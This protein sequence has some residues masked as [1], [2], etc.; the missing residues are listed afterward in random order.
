MPS[1]KAYAAT[2]LWAR[3]ANHVA[4]GSV[5]VHASDAAMKARRKTIIVEWYTL[6]R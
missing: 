5:A 2:L 6:A 1:V 4:R 3:L